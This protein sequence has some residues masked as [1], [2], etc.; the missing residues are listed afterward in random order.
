MKKQELEQLLSDKARLIEELEIELEETNQGII[1]LMMELEEL[2]QEK[3]RENIDLIKQLQVELADTN[4]GLLALAVELEQSEEKYSSI[5]KN[6]AETIF[7]FTEA[8]VVETTNPAGAEL[9]GYDETELLG[10]NIS[11]LIPKF[12]QIAPELNLDE[13]ISQPDGVPVVYGFHKNGTAFPIE[14]TLGRPVYANK[15]QWLV[16]IRDIT[17]RKKAEEGFRLMAKIFEGST[18]AIV[19]TNTRSRITDA[20]EAFTT[21]TGYEK[22][23][24]LGRHPSLLSS[25]KHNSHFYFGLRRTLLKTGAWSGEVWSKRKNDEIYPIWLSIYSVKDENNATTHFVGIFSDITARKN[26]ENQLKQLAHYDAL[27]GLANRTQFV[28]RLKWTLEVA[29]RNAGQAALMFLDLDRFKLINDTLGHQA[30]DQLLIEVARRL[31]ESV[32]EIDTVSRLAG[33]EFTVILTSIKTPEE[34]GIVAKKILKA[35]NVPVVLEGREVFISTSIG[36]TVYPVDGDSV[37]QL[38]K[39]ADTAMYHA[40]ERG[41]NNFQYFS[42]TMN[43]KVLDELEMETNLRQALKNNEFSLNYQ[44]QFDLRTKEL[45]GL[46]VLL[47]WKHPMLGFISPA[48]FIPHAEK[49]DLIITIGEW[50]LRTACLRSVAWQAAGLRPVRISVNLSGMQLKQHDLIDKITQILIET[51]LSSELL[52][53]ELTEGVLMDN[54][55]VTIHTLTELKKMGIHLSI[56]DFGTGYSS[57]SYLKRFPIDT[58]KID[59]SFVKDITTDVDDNAIASTIIAMAHNLRLKVIAEGVETQEQADVLQEKGCDEV[60]GYFFSRPLTEKGMCQLLA[61]LKN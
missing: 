37:N 47:R 52:E 42:N 60:Q 1:Q 40:K 4:K 3:L 57:L 50:V 8:G 24:V 33:D 38:V 39:N 23:E 2:E 41:R 12:N 32:R 10:I 11:V 56:D 54:A 28:E 48:V 5:L 22:S 18:D 15:R 51:K 59:Q 9:F 26:A 25:H 16:I 43:Q 21:I 6:A 7:T 30:G 31:T 20:N 46:E 45:I 27:T 19:I 17:A 58:L 49:S 13:N 53:L 36:I 34:A 29:K 14:F 44:P 61:E 35:L 55:E